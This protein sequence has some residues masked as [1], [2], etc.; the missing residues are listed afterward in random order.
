MVAVY[1]YYPRLPVLSG[2]LGY[3]GY[4]EYLGC[5][6][7]LACVDCLGCLVY[8]GCLE[9]LGCLGCVG[10]WGYL[11]GE[12]TSH[13]YYYPPPWLLTMSGQISPTVVKYP[14]L[15]AH[16]SPTGGPTAGKYPRDRG[17]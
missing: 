12:S 3:L 13:F 2:Y 17:K 9:Y 1:Y 11:A 8:L 15:G 14:Q 5:L 16:R 6:E 10:I 4:L 7:Y